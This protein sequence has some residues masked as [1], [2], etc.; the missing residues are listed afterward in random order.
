MR[1]HTFVFLAAFFL[2]AANFPNKVHASQKVAV[3]SA[4]LTGLSSPVA[5]K[6]DRRAE[7]LKAYLISYNSPLAPY[8]KTFID[9][10]DKN[11]LDWKLI[12]AISGVESYFGQLIPT[13]SNNGWGYNI[14][15]TNTRRFASWEDGIGVVSKAV[16]VDYINRY[17][18]DIYSIGSAYAADRLW[19]Y[20]VN[21]YMNDMNAFELS[22]LN[23]TLSISL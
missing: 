20:K 7:I 10:A 23:N 18:D 22:Y 1:K 21:N 6:E 5:V 3:S 13:Y 8:A 17:G 12:P 11:N 16:R 19:A 9:E 2:I 14:F 4:T 15:G